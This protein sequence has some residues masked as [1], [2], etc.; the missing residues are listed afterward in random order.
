MA[1]L[2]PAT[3]LGQGYTFTGARDSVHRDGGDGCSRGGLLRGEGLLQG[4]A[5]WRRSPGMA[6]AAGGTHPTG[7]HS[8]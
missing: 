2:P 1:L 5:W 3:K 8:S 7:M 6:T 4:F